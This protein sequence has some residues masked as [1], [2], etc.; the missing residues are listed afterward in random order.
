MIVYIETC[1]KRK[2][3]IPPSIINDMK[4]SP[5]INM[6]LLELKARGTNNQKIIDLVLQ[7]RGIL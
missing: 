3:P 7:A 1:L 4:T 6:S 5:H 2:Q